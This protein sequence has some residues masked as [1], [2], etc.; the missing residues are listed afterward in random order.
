MYLA[1][2]DGSETVFERYRQALSREPL[3]PRLAVSYQ[4]ILG[5]GLRRFGR[6]QQALQAFDRAIV[7][8][9]RHQLNLLLIEAE[10]ARNAKPA[11]APKPER[12][13]PIEFGEATKRVMGR[14]ETMSAE[15]AG[16]GV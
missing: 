4:R 3:N 6:E 15:L 12:S 9:E 7:I 8:A 5:E 1:T 16:A 2:L 11:E 10:T 13:Q 14:I